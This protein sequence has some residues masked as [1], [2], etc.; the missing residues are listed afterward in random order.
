MKKGDVMCPGCRA[1][2]QRLELDVGPPTKGKYRCP[3]CGY[4]L[5][6]FDGSKHV[7]YRLTVRPIKV[8]RARANP[9]T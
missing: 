5:E 9:A 1:S 8:F 3:S 4:I 2:F 7:A 6:I